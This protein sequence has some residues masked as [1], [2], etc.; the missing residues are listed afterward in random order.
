M[1]TRMRMVAG[2]WAGVKERG[3]LMMVRMV[4]GMGVE[5][6]GRSVLVMVRMAMRMVTNEVG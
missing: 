4:A 1:R 5:I 2:M 6:K 3:V